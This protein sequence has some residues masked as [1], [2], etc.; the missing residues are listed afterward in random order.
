M[1]NGI[2]NLFLKGRTLNNLKNPQ[3]GLQVGIEM[4]AAREAAEAIGAQIVL[5]KNASAGKICKMLCSMMS[6]VIS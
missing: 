4:R 1:K 3:A 6:G 5:G 2:Q